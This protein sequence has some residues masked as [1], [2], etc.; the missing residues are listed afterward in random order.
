[1]GFRKYETLIQDFQKY[2]LWRF[3]NMCKLKNCILGDLVLNGRM[4][5]ILDCL[6]VYINRMKTL[7]LNNLSIMVRWE[8]NQKMKTD[9]ERLFTT[10][11]Y[12]YYL[13]IF[14][15]IWIHTR[16]IFKKSSWVAPR[17]VAHHTI[18]WIWLW[19]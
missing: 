13:R 15:K 12:F 16:E 8:D 7:V 11:L 3:Y 5:T 2:Q 14:K 17:E 4:K 19:N 1:M 18:V 6:R 9:F 10:L